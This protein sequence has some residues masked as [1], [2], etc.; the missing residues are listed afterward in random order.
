MKLCGLQLRQLSVPYITC[1]GVLSFIVTYCT[2]N[3]LLQNGMGTVFLHW[4][5]LMTLCTSRPV[6]FRGSK[7]VGGKHTQR[8]GVE[9]EPQGE[10]SGSGVA[11][12]R[13]R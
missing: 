5:K 1:N 2:L 12:T 10:C 4:S 11:G 7:G 6:T 9:A 3:A 13:G 8:A